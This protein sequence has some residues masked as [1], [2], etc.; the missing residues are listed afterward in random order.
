MGLV[1][2]V[3]P[4]AQVMDEAMRYARILAEAGP[5]AVQAIKRSVLTGLEYPPEL[6]L[7]KEMEIGIPVSLSEDCREGTRAFKE[8]RKPVFRGR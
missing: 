7:E 6:A 4:P 8:K 2:K 1:N 3:V 5:L